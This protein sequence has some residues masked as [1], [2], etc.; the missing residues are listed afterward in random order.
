MP[1]QKDLKR[2]VRSRMQKTGESY[3]AARSQVVKPRLALAPEPPADYAGL[4]GTSDAAVQKAT[5]RTWAEW[6]PVLDA[7]GGRE[8]PHRDVAI[9]VSS[10]GVRD[11]WSQT[12]VVGYERIRGLR[13]IGQR[14]EGSWE[15]SKSRTFNVPLA[16]LYAAF[17]DAKKRA[18]WL[19]GT[20]LTVRS[21]TK[22]KT[23]RAVLDDGTAVQFYFT[24][25]GES[26][27]GVA[28]Q[29]TKLAS[30]V[31]VD[32]RKMF[33]SERLEALSDMLS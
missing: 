5:G 29:H 9:Y 1:Q 25:K 15:A 20:K 11:W 16:T 21:S 28:V 6:V 13:A 26:K 32:E 27:T 23:V 3:T 31:A 10:L 19:P 4:A 14:R 30:K 33:W 18:K 8:K 12:V 17:A 7:F 22:D 2:I 24:P